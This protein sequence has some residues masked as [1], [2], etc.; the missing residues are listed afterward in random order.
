MAGLL[1]N[2]R[3][4]LLCVP[5]LVLC[6]IDQTITLAG[7]SSSY[8]SG[9]YADANEVNPLF[10]WLLQQHPLAF[11]AG[12]L[13]WILLFGAVIMVLP[14]RAAMAASIAIVLGH[15]W[16]TATWL[17]LKIHHGYWIALGLFLASAIVIVLTWEK[18]CGKGAAEAPS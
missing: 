8:W 5:P 12:I 9:N 16:G 2:R 13:A 7:Q 3:K 14:R 10:N 6:A 18:Y 15:T 4:L 17:C 11:E 1:V